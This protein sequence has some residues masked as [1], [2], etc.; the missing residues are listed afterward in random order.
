MYQQLV[1]ARPFLIGFCFRSKDWTRGRAMYVYLCNGQVLEMPKVTSF[2]MD[3]DNL[4]L[5]A[6]KKVVATLLRSDV[7]FCSKVQACSSPC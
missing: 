4:L 3:S 7:F 2:R 6:G 5:C 1:F